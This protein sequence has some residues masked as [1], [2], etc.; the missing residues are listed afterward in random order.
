MVTVVAGIRTAIQGRFFALVLM[1]GLLGIVGGR[2][3]G[4]PDFFFD[5][6]FLIVSTDD[7]GVQ[8]HPAL[9]HS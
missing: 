7:V 4:H 9:L 3:G 1:V 8:G 5:F 6:F 2:N